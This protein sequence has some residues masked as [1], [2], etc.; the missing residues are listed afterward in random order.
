MHDVFLGYGDPDSA[1]YS[2]MPHQVR[3]AGPSAFPHHQLCW[4]TRV[5]VVVALRVENMMC[6]DVSGAIGT[7]VGTNVGI[8]Q[9]LSIR[10]TV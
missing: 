1:H 3:P 9:E 5:L 4:L 6:R 2:N 7:T 10:Q 8:A